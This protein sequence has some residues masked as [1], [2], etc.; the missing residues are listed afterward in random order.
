MADFTLED[1][2]A[3]ADAGKVVSIENPASSLFW[4]LGR[5]KRVINRA[6]VQCVPIAYCAYG[7]KYRKS[8][9]LLVANWDGAMEL[10]S[11]CTCG[12]NHEEVLMGS[13]TSKAAEYPEQ[14]VSKWTGLLDHRFR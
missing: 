2:E 4:K 6:H 5:T 12:V 7:T 1:F 3:R 8:T 11:T 10:A 9:L 14:L 13:K